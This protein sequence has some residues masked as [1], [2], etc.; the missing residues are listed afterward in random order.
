MDKEDKTL[1]FLTTFL[2]LFVFW[3]LLS[4]HF[5]AE[6]LILG[7]IS[8]LLV[9]HFTGDLLITRKKIIFSL[10]KIVPFIQYLFYLTY[11]IILANIDVAYRVLHPRMPI[12]PRIVKFKSR[13][14]SD[15]GQTALANSIT[16]TPGTIT[17]DVK[18]GTFYVHA[19]S[20]KSAEELL[21][22]E[23]ENKLMKIFE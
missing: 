10:R 21:G 23:M 15:I 18:Y 19:L 3:I 7:L 11:S 16:L 20:D 13:L 5:D 2:I 12:N 22:G 1:R 8:S 17:V 4:W 9:T 14:K 6:H